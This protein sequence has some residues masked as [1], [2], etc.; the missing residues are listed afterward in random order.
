MLHVVVHLQ[1]LKSIVVVRSWHSAAITAVFPSF[2]A[3]VA[4]FMTWPQVPAAAA[5]AAAGPAAAAMAVPSCHTLYQHVQR[6]QQQQA[7]T[8]VPAPA[9]AAV[10]TAGAVHTAV[11]AVGVFH[12]HPN[13]GCYIPSMPQ[14]T[15]LAF[16]P[17]LGAIGSQH[18]ALVGQ[19]LLQAAGGQQGGALVPG[20]QQHLPTQ[21]QGLSKSV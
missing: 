12:N 14:L 13:Q 11:G 16:R 8:T 3:A 1:G 17:G 6:G 5:A 7:T 2:A 10:G 18:K 21:H 19:V 20:G 4:A 9:L 15:V